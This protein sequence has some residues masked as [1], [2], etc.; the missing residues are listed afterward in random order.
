MIWLPCFCKRILN[1]VSHKG[2]RARMQTKSAS[3]DL[4]LCI[5]LHRKGGAEGSLA[6]YGDLTYIYSNL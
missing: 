3:G 5:A 6:D 1:I 2:V 4:L